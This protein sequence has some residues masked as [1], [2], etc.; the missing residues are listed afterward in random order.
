M[1][2]S[3][4]I[5]GLMIVFC[6]GCAQENLRTDNS[7][8]VKFRSKPGIEQLE[9]LEKY[10]KSNNRGILSSIVVVYNNIN[11]SEA[12][13]IDAMMYRRYGYHTILR[14]QPGGNEHV[15]VLLE[16]DKN[17]EESCYK[18]LLSDFEWYKSS[19]KSI[20]DYVDATI[21]DITDNDTSTRM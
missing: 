11:K 9:N 10:I 21:C 19:E 5:F 14:F 4:L 16:Y 12:Y 20:K 18:Y 6:S 13:Y 1:S 7:L 8:L 15:S 2:L 17:S 3:K